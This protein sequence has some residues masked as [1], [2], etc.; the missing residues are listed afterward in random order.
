M[1]V[2]PQAMACCTCQ[3]VGDIVREMKRLSILIIFL[4]F[5]LGF[6]C[7]RS[8]G[9]EFYGSYS[10]YYVVCEKIELDFQSSYRVEATISS[11]DFVGHFSDKM[12]GKYEMYGDSI[13]IKWTSVNKDNDSYKSVPTGIDTVLLTNSPDTIRFISCGEHK[14]TDCRFIKQ[15]SGI[16]Y[17]LF[18]LALCIAPFYF[19]GRYFYKR[20]NKE[21]E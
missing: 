14:L 3:E 13:F 15:T 1:D 21:D 20:M 6:S 7:N 17:Q 12:Y 9:E 2:R 4:H 5:I 11:T 19:I 10:G 8:K 18:I 16:A